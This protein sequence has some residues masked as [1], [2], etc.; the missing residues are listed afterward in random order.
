M[1]ILAKHRNFSNNK[2]SKKMGRTRGWVLFPKI[3]LF[4]NWK[5]NGVK[6]IQDIRIIEGKNKI[7]A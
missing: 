3:T 6:V 7:T 2:N 4:R 1:K 5:T